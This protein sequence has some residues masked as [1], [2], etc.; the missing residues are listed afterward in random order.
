[1]DKLTLASRLSDLTSDAERLANTIY[2]DQ[3]MP[4]EW[5]RRSVLEWVFVDP[6]IIGGAG[7]KAVLS[8]LR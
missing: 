6:P 7:I 1:M 8:L 2:L 4:D 5:A 3:D